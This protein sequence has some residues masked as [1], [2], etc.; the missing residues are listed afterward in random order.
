MPGADAQHPG[1]LKWYVNGQL[2]ET[3]NGGWYNP[4]GS[5]NATAPFDQP[6]YII[7]NLAVG[8]PNTAYTGNQSPVDGTYTMQIT[9][10]EAFAFPERG[11]FDRNGQVEGADIAAML[12]ALCDEPG[13]AAAHG[14]TIDQLAL[15]GDLD[16]DGKFT[17]V[18]LQSL[19]HKLGTAASGNGPLTSVPEPASLILMALG[20][21]ALLRSKGARARTR[22]GK[23][24]QLIAG[25]RL[26]GRPLASHQLRRH[27]R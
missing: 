4:P 24:P 25:G 6:F 21:V 22:N 18:D 16:G 14:L 23:L 13:F 19:L 26:P 5:T 9:D 2:Y 3:R 11:D 12:N 7:M 10:V 27:A 20:G 17:N 1:T 8:G 15:I